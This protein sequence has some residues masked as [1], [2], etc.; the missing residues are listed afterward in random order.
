MA[1][2]LL[3]LYAAMLGG[4]LLLQL[5]FGEPLGALFATRPVHLEIDLA[6]G[7]GVG[8]ATVLG[9]RASLAFG[10]ARRMDQAFRKMLAP[11]RPSDAFGL[12]L[13]SALAEELFFRGLLQPRLGLVATALLFGVVHVPQR[14]S[15]IPWTLGAIAMGF[16]LGLL[17]DWRAGILAPTLAHFTVNYFNLHH[18]VGAANSSVDT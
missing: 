15:Q 9:W 7:L 6:I 4:T 11:V 17:Y 10:W 8:L 3:L 5:G 2:T 14:R 13:M 18:L 16:V 12:A 1:H